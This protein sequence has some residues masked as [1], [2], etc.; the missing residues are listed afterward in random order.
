MAFEGEDSSYTN[1]V[2]NK[3]GHPSGRGFIARVNQLLRDRNQAAYFQCDSPS[4]SKGNCFPYSL[5]QQL[6]RS[7]IYATLTDEIKEL[8]ENYHYL[9]QAIVHFVQ[10][11]FQAVHW[12]SNA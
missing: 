6:H 10:V 7:E 12:L 11:C 8:C 3:M 2:F 1:R 5:M 4:E 9:R